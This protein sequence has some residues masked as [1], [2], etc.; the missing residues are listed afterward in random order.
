MTE[1]EIKTL[2]VPQKQHTCERKLHKLKNDPGR[3]CNEAD[4]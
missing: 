4:P 1:L 2:G 3:Q